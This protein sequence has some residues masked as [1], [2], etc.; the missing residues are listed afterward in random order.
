MSKSEVSPPGVAHLM[1][2]RRRHR[3][4]DPPRGHRHRRR[5]PLR[6]D[7]QARRD[8]NLLEILAALTGEDPSAVAHALHAATAPLKDDVAGLVVE[9]LAPIRAATRELRADPAQLASMAAAG[10]ERAE[11]VAGPVYERAARAMGL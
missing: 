11:A 6:P 9:T 7:D 3:A 2:D 8:S 4:Q 1:D 5:G 10:A